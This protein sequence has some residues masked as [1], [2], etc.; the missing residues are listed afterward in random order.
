LTALYGTYGSSPWKAKALVGEL[1]QNEELADVLPAELAYIFTE[2]VTV[3]RK[4]GE[5]FAKK[6]DVRHGKRGYRIVR[7]EQSEN[8]KAA[9]RWLVLVN[10]P[11]KGQ[12]GQKGQRPS[13]PGKFGEKQQKVTGELQKDTKLQNF[14]GLGSS[15]PSDPSDPSQSASYSGSDVGKGEVSNVINLGRPRD[16]V[17]VET[18]EDITRLV[19]AITR[20]DILGVDLETTDKRW[21][22]GEIR[23][24]SVTTP[25]GETFVVD[26]NHPNVD[27]AVIYAALTGKHIVSHNAAFDAAFLLRVGCRPSRLSCTMVLNQLRYAG[28]DHMRHGLAS[29]VEAYTSIGLAKDV[30]HECWRRESLTEQELTYAADDSRYLLEVYDQLAEVLD[31]HVGMEEVAD[32]EVRFTK[33]VAAMSEVGMPA[34]LDLWGA[35]IEEKREEKEKL[36]E[37]LDS[38]IGDVE[39]PE[40]FVK[41][42]K[43]NDNVQ[44]S[45]DNK[46][47]WAS[48]DQKRWAIAEVLGLELPTRNKKK[49]GEWV[50]VE[51]LDKDHIHLLK[52]PIGEALKEYQAI[53]NFPATFEGAVTGEDSR[54][55]EGRIYPERKQLRARTGRMSCTNPP[56]HNPPKKTAIREAIVAPD[57]KALISCDFS[58]IEPRVLAALSRD[59]ALISIF[60][61]GK[62]SYK[63]VAAR[64]LGKDEAQVT[65]DERK[66]F[67]TV[68]LGLIY[69][70]TIYG[71]TLR[72]H[73]EIDP[74]I[75]VDQIE[76]YVDAVFAA[77]PAVDKWRSD[78][79]AEF[80]AGSR[81]T[82]ILLGRR[83]MKV[84][85]KRQR[86]NAPIQGTAC[87]LFKLASVELAERMSDVGG[88]DIVALIHDEVVIEVHEDRAEEVLEWTKKVMQETAERV[89]NRALPK[90]LTIPVAVDGGY[91]KTLQE[92][93]D[94]AG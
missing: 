56:M 83:R 15:D 8:S 3:A 82:R 39:P 79:E 57:G 41:A 30:D 22:I 72:V 50:K 62:D 76:G 74:G 60:K 70:M 48:P 94:A 37:L 64:A 67:K 16:Y 78:L 91:G 47:N 23:V 29:V 73:R 32:L 26:V 24:I 5:V 85:N 35:A 45:R 87:D 9:A 54:Y 86:W 12:K 36:V 19:R 43:G 33:V 13:A 92:A 46:I 63:N 27:A 20:N 40:K 66:I 90:S 38:Y 6:A 61:S 34:D 80:E 21:F 69:G 89:I 53:A 52:H 65:D 84:E 18:L 31:E 68:L 58:Q 7:C 11:P 88:F 17:L 77:F 81:E 10:E 55:H 4:F 2:G 25:E 59:P 28:L 51:T 1:D 49:N 75:H 71:L 93:K 14:P 42:N 44:T